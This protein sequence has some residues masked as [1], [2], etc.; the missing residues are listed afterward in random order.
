MDREER[1]EKLWLKDFKKGSSKMDEIVRLLDE[2]EG[3]LGHY[4]EIGGLG[5]PYHETDDNKIKECVAK[6]RTEIKHNKKNSHAGCLWDFKN[7]GRF[8]CTG[9]LDGRRIGIIEVSRPAIE[10]GSD[11]PKAWKEF[12][13]GDDVYVSGI[14]LDDKTVFTHHFLIQG[15][16]AFCKAQKKNN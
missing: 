11:N 8:L 4:S 7:K 15:W 16:E 1:E 13:P 3:A 10:R 9:E 12:K 5:C 2:I 6:I 14:Y